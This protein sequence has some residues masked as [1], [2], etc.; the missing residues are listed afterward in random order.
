[1]AYERYI[2]K[3]GKI[4]GPYVQHNKKVHGKVVTEYPGKR[5]QNSGPKKSR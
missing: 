2:K 4:Y 5:K 1:M 3:N